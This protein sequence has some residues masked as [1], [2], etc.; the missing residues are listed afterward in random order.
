M[1]HFFL[2]KKKN[3]GGDKGNAS[4]ASKGSV[5]S[6]S[7]L[8][9]RTAITPRNISTQFGTNARARIEPTAKE[10]KLSHSKTP[11]NRSDEK[12]T[13]QATEP[14]RLRHDVKLICD[15]FGI[16][17]QSR[18]A[19]R[20]FDATKLEDFS[21]MTNEDFDDL[22]RTQARMG[23]PIC[24]LQQRKLR[25]LLSWVRS[26]ADT[27]NLGKDGIPVRPPSYMHEGIENDDGAVKPRNKHG[28][29]KGGET[30]I[31]A[32]WERRFYSDLP[33]LRKKLQK[34]GEQQSHSDW[35]TR[36]ASWIFCDCDK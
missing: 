34:L 31:P 32:D 6:R 4:I 25:V 33:S 12:R 20:I 8:R 2:P 27:G 9:G 15:E 16:A 10:A 7:D 3:N 21:L 14:P 23:R 11:S 19:L 24:P 22:V 35:V 13:P 5:L 30:L 1:S 26:L 18:Y 28:H 29:R 36:F 17:E